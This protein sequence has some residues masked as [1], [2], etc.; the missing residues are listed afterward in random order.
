MSSDDR[1]ISDYG[2]TYISPRKNSGNPIYIITIK[3][4]PIEKRASILTSIIY[5]LESTCFSVM[6]GDLVLEFNRNSFARRS[7]WSSINGSRKIRQ[8]DVRNSLTLWFYRWHFRISLMDRYPIHIDEQGTRLVLSLNN[9]DFRSNG[10]S[11]EWIPI[12][13]K[14]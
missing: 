1:G 14:D 8:K 6:K 5:L 2:L 3:H 11:G 4:L 9:Y 7:I 12:K 13:L 10:T